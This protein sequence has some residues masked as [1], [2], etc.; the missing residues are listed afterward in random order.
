MGDLGLGAVPDSCYRGVRP[1]ACAQ[2]CLKGTSETGCIQAGVNHPRIAGLSD[3]TLVGVD[4]EVSAGS[5]ASLPTVKTLKRGAATVPS[6]R[7]R[8]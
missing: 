5:D 6:S 8:V 4:S 2:L 7:A 3:A 1:D